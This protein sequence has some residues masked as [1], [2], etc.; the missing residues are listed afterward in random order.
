[1]PTSTFLNL[2]KEKKQRIMEAALDE[3][4]Q[5]SYDDS[6]ISRI[7]KQAGIPRGSFY[8][9]F[10][11]KEDLYLYVISIIAEEKKKLLF[12][13]QKKLENKPFFEIYKGIYIKGLEFAQKHPQYA[14]IAHLM[15]SRP[16]EAI[17]EKIYDKGSKECDVVFSSLIEKAILRGELKEGINSDL[18]SRVLTAISMNVFQGYLEEWEGHNYEQLFSIIDE[19]ICMLEYGIKQQ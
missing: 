14:Q 4:A 9:Y 12:P 15:V 17:K 7:V 5:H 1:M 11:D 3:F 8:Q 16:N 13:A 10:E 19:V 6:N 18:L 2:C